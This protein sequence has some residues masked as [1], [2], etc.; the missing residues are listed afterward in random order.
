MSGEQGVLRNGK[1]VAVKK[2]KLSESAKAKEEFET[3]MA[4]ISNIHHRNLV[5]LLGCC[6]KGPDLL[7]VYEY[8]EKGGL[9]QYLFGMPIW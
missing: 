3:E 7:F 5:P 6:K 1:C 2:M 4:L 8:M 9:D